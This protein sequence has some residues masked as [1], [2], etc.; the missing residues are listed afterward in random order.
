ML[1]KLAL[2]V[3]C[4]V[5][6]NAGPVLILRKKVM[7]M[8]VVIRCLLTS[9]VSCSSTPCMLAGERAPQSVCAEKKS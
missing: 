1:F 7:M 8:M 6:V 9:L 4:F 5:A 3:A 2:L